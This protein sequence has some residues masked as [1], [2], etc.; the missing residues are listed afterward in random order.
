MIH[1]SQSLTKGQDGAAFQPIITASSCTFP[2]PFHLSLH[3]EHTSAHASYFKIGDG[4]LMSLTFN[5]NSPF[6]LLLL[7]ISAT[8]EEMKREHSGLHSITSPACMCVAV[9]IT[10][11]THTLFLSH[12]LPVPPPPP[13]Q[14]LPHPTPAPSVAHVPQHTLITPVLLR[15]R[16]EEKKSPRSS[17][18]GHQSAGASSGFLRKQRMLFLINLE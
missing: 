5:A 2:C 15:E 12:P 8:S 4:I 7:L 13:P 6:S 14:L 16:R 18:E 10:L 1:H 11:S 9:T 3:Q 17:P